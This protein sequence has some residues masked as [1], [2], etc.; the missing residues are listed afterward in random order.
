MACI[1]SRTVWICGSVGMACG[2][3]GRP[4]GT[5]A[6]RALCPTWPPRDRAGTLAAPCATIRVICLALGETQRTGDPVSAEV[7][8]TLDGV[9][10]RPQATL[11]V[12]NPHT[13]A[14]EAPPPT[15]APT[16]PT[17]P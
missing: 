15:A 12:L 2:S 4:P 13:R 10:H 9:S 17:P 8:M 7:P 16:S 14:P 6:V 11:H 3:P 5:G 1:W